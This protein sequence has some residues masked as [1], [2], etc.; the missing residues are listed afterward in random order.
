[1]SNELKSMA[2]M[3][4]IPKKKHVAV[5]TQPPT[6]A[7][8]Q[9]AEILELETRFKSEQEALRGKNI[10]WH[11]SRRPATQAVDACRRLAER[12]TNVREYHLVAKG[13]SEIF[14]ERILTLVSA[15]GTPPGDLSIVANQAAG[16]PVGA[17]AGRL[18]NYLKTALAD[19]E[20]AF[21]SEAD[22]A[23]K[24]CESAPD[25]GPLLADLDSI[26]ASLG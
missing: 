9:A 6:E 23:R 11:E 18:V 15:G 22:E 14:D 5:D 16:D 7:E 8:R 17:T 13:H 26:I 20:L 3:T 21:K 2:E 25:P 4:H 19:L 24:L 1:M 10:E 12:L